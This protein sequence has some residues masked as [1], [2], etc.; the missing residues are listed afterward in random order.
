VKICRNLIE[1]GLFQDWE[2]DQL[3]QLLFD[4]YENL[5]SLEKVIDGEKVHQF[6][7]KV[8]A[9]DLA[10]IREFICEILLHTLYFYRD[11]E[12]LRIYNKHYQSKKRFES[13]KEEDLNELV[14]CND[15]IKIKNSDFVRKIMSI[16]FGYVLSPN[17][18]Q[19][20]KM[21][22]EN[23]QR[24]V[25]KIMPFFFRM[26]DPY[27]QS[28]LL[29][30]DK[31]YS[32]FMNKFKPI[33]P[34]E[35]SEVYGTFQLFSERINTLFNQTK[36]GDFFQNES[37][38]IDQLSL[39][40]KDLQDYINKH[41]KRTEDPVVW[42]AATHL[43][44]EL[45]I[46]CKLMHILVIYTEWTNM[47]EDIVKGVL[48]T[49]LMIASDSTINFDFFVT[50]ISFLEFLD[51]LL[52][53]FPLI[54]LDFLSGLLGKNRINF[55]VSS[56]L[57]DIILNFTKDK[58]L[59]ELA[60]DTEEN[61]NGIRLML[62]ASKSLQLLS[63]YLDYRLYS[64][65]YTPPLYDLHISRSLVSVFLQDLAKRG[66]KILE[67]LQGSLELICA[68][69]D[70]IRSERVPEASE[71]FGEF[72]M[73]FLRTLNKSMAFR[74]KYD[75]YHKLEAAF[76]LKQLTDIVAI[77][78]NNKEYC[79][80]LLDFISIMY[81]DFKNCLLTERT[82]YFFTKPLDMQYEED[83]F[84]ETE[85]SEILQLLIKQ[86]DLFMKEY[87]DTKDDAK[88]EI[89][90]TYAER[91]I[92]SHMIKMLNFFMIFRDQDLFKIKK[93]AS[94]IEALYNILFNEREA[95]LSIFKSKDTLELK[96]IDELE[97][98]LAEF[99]LEKK[100]EK[101]SIR[102]FCMASFE[103][104]SAIVRPG[105]LEPHKKKS[106]SQKSAEQK[107]KHLFVRSPLPDHNRSKIKTF[108]SYMAHHY[109]LTT[110]GEQLPVLG[111]RFMRKYI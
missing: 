41:P 9:T 111:K 104:L 4:K 101:I 88:S 22:T 31:Y 48:D 36:T 32:F 19:K 80:I 44:F 45:F 3:I 7:T 40:S 79:G 34:N 23:A 86:F 91:H 68:P 10:M 38:C 21:L 11:R 67:R 71:K 33:R 12:V 106:L 27:Q 14:Q 8:W 51:K 72:F 62:V 82:K 17:N 87:S 47:K 30:N 35:D 77:T 6:W 85:Y 55:V 56:A 61:A 54:C 90:K 107:V 64:N 26:P 75:V 95:L 94:T 2:L 18:I 15:L 97:L 100:R 39:L 29:C 37:A 43:F 89:L 53:H 28:L 57:F 70:E 60:H 103:I 65:F 81:I 1:I 46:P 78:Q 24:L 25:L 66:T 96:T 109:L 98:S 63:E 16:F 110:Q 13:M 108:T 73:Q 92:F 49:F 58:I 83:I 74:F 69:K 50:N 59:L 42:G 76:K 102:V 52:V 93:H 20:C 84:F 105:N 5:L 99:S